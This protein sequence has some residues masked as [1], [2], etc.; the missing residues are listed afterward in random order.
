MTFE[1]RARLGYAILAILL[2]AG[3]VYAIRR[4]SVLADEQ[5]E[6]LRAE[7]EQVTLA[8][9]LRWSSELLVSAGRGYLLSGDPEL[10]SEVRIARTRFDDNVH[11][12]RDQPLSPIGRRLVS[13]TQ[14]AAAA[15]VHIQDQLLESRRSNEPAAA[16][17]HR[18]DTELL[19][20]S[21]T[22][23][24]KLNALVAFKEEALAQHY[25]DARSERG[26]LEIWLF[27]LLGVLVAASV[28]V[29]SVFAGRLAK[30]YRQVR[31]AL[32]A[33]RSAVAT[34]DEVMAI[35]AHDLRNPLGAITMRAS[36][37]RDQ[38]S[39]AQTRQHAELIVNTGLRM[40]YLIKTM[41]DVATMEA[42]RF[43]LISGPCK[44]DELLDEI[45]ALFEPTA[46]AKK[47]TLARR[48]AETGLV[49][50]AD[51]ERVLQVLSNLIGNA[52]KFTP[53]GGTITLAVERIDESARFAVIDTG[54]GI[55]PDHL[56]RIF[57]RF[58]KEERVPGV[59]GT[60]LGLFI[61][62]RIVEG[63]GGQIWAESE[64]GQGARFYFTLPLEISTNVPMAKTVPR[65]S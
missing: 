54:P 6:H 52:L 53:R 33:A 28:A 58:W 24:Q 50:H 5:V 59:K 12:L 29:S 9:R 26:R 10:L 42:G 27:G 47:V 38:S 17:A 34:R 18:F 40:E 55:S 41:L 30:A 45:T 60:G 48:V 62:K 20:L 39:V 57:E 61:A 16:L 19:A 13:E 3:A 11:L 64:H 22:L 43:S 2:L 15:F 63:H 31:D 36:L 49:I 35:V 44:V 4:L 14:Q 23:D 8:E 25:S 46:A 1:S 7:E 56:Q 37:M 32:E 65:P 21:R 51:R